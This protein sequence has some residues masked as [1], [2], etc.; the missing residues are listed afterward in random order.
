MTP[1]ARR[2][3]TSWALLILAAVAAIVV[4][5]TREAPGTAE[6]SER[7][8][9]LLKVLNEGQI[10][11]IEFETAGKSFALSRAVSAAGQNSNGAEDE[12]A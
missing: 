5:A 4:V 11:R 12:G 10:S 1:D 3:V 9:S 6:L 8:R 7:E 2:L